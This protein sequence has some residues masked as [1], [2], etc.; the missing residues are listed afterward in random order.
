MKDLSLHLLDIAQNSVTAGSSEITIGI[1][2]SDRLDMISISVE[3][4]GCGMDEEFLKR[5]TDPFT[6]SRTTRKVGMGIPLFKLAAEMTGGSLDITSRVGQGTRISASFGKSH[7]DRP[8]LGDIDGTI[9]TLIQGSPE[10]DFV[11]KHVT[12]KG[13]FTMETKTFKEEL[14][15]IPLNE[16]EVLNWIAGWLQENRENIY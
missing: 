4:N 10:I 9:I 11:Y 3:D 1:V 6:T 7:I 2:D 15:D 13:G 5:V 12:D 16:P 8:P 14:G